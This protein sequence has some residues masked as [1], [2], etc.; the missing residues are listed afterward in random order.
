MGGFLEEGE[1][2]G[3]EEEEAGEAEGAS[4]GRDEGNR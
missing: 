2:E 3:E 4:L 1:G